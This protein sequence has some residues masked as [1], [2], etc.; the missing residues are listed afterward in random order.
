[1]YLVGHVYWGSQRLTVSMYIV[2]VMACVAVYVIVCVTVCVIVYLILETY[3]TS[4]CLH[5]TQCVILCSSV[6]TR[7]HV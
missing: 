7:V 3:V 2:Y 1:M 6:R 5:E 4:D